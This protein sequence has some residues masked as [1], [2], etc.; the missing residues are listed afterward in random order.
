MKKLIDWILNIL[1]LQ[2]KPRQRQ[3]RICA[4]CGQQIKKRDRWHRNPTPEH[5]DCETKQGPDVDKNQ[6][7]LPL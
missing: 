3:K 1:N 2:R 5:W 4:K 6:E 7:K